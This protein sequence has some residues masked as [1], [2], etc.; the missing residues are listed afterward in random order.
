MA[1]SNNSLNGG[2]L[3]LQAPLEWQIEQLTQQEFEDLVL[4]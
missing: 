3:G 1:L 4:P 2:A